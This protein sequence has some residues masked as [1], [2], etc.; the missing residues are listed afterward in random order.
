MVTISVMLWYACFKALSL[1]LGRDQTDNHIG[2]VCFT[3]VVT[4]ASVAFGIAVAC[5]HIT[6]AWG[7]G[8]G[9]GLWAAY[10]CALILFL[11]LS[12]AGDNERFAAFMA[13][14][15]ASLVTCLLMMGTHYFIEY[16]AK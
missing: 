4:V 15:F 7:L 11:K 5:P 3:S 2:L 6:V 1:I 16:A 13:T 8:I 14:S 9:M 10:F 12:F